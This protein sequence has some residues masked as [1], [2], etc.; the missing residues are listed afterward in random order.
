VAPNPLAPGQG[1]DSTGKYADG[2]IG[3]KL[4][5]E[6]NPF[7][8]QYDSGSFEPLTHYLFRFPAKFHPPVVRSLLE[9][10]S[11]P[12]DR[13]F[14]PFCGSGTLL[15][16]A[17]ATGRHAIGSDV[18][19][20]AVFASQTKVQRYDVATLIGTA[21]MLLKRLKDFERSQ[22]EYEARQFDDIS[23]EETK[24]LLEENKLWVPAIP[25]L[26][27]W[28]RRYV[29][30]DLARIHREISA[31]S[32]PAS[33][34]QLFL[35]CFAGIIRAASN[36]DPVP[37]SG[38]EVTSHMRKK[39]LK[40]R[41]INPFA[42]FS[43]SIR[44]AL[45]ASSAFM[46]R[47]DGSLDLRAFQADATVVSQA[48]QG[49]K[50]DCAITSPPYH[51]AVDYYRRHQLEMFWLGLV[52]DQHQR[53]EILQHYIGRPKV[54]KRHPRLLDGTS[55]PSLIA[56]WEDI[57]RDESPQRA[58]AFRHYM[59]S[60]QLALQE[61]AAVLARNRLAVLIL[62]RSA[63]NGCQIPTEAL[64]EQLA[65]PLFSL[66]EIYSYPTKNRYMSYSRR[67]GANIDREYVLAFRR[68][69]DSVCSHHR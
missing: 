68:T 29:V 1:S 48:L 41:V 32:A 39:D 21:E 22:G 55:L 25:L 6:S 63:W 64:F 30:V 58:D 53:L 10:Y 14:D 12:G 17:G 7:Q 67:N 60:M 44:R 18:D 20:V 50:I 27:H 38:L 42:L 23:E 13:V 43:K 4:G 52:S 54:A 66:D 34:R 65:S 69:S 5:I 15:V 11:A 62:G 45:V 47:V 36:A 49:Q 9:R 3:S 56:E 61:M 16:E 40:G 51:N 33:H 2:N 28:F 37:V 26:F 57:I 31:L 59:R 19:P 35:L 8:L 24:A 46:S